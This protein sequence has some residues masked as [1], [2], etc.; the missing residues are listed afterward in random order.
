MFTGCG[1]KWNG[2][3]GVQL[4]TLKTKTPIKRSAFNS[5]KDIIL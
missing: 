3:G 4:A 1:K 2:L 5:K